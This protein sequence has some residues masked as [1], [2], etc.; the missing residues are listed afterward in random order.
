VDVPETTDV[1]SFPAEEREPGGEIDLGDVVICTDQ[2]A[3]QAAA[4]GR[5]YLRELEVLA[6]HGILHLLGHDHERDHGEMARLERRLRP[7]VAAGSV[8]C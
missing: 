2:A 5:G 1:L 8:P 4:A 6:L 3:R 7:R